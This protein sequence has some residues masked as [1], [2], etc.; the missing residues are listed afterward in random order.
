MIFKIEDVLK[1]DEYELTD[2]ITDAHR[3]EINH[4]VRE[5]YK[6]VEEQQKTIEYQ[7][8]LLSEYRSKIDDIIDI[9]Y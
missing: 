9:V 5:L 6:L 3:G 8:D 2:Y 7:K 4:L 1:L